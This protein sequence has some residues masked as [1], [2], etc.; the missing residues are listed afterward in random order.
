MD[1]NYVKAKSNPQ[2][3]DIRYPSFYDYKMDKKE[4][5]KVVQ[6]YR[7]QVQHRMTQEKLG[8]LTNTSRTYIAD[9]ERGHKMPSELKRLSICRVLNIPLPELFSDDELALITPYGPLL[10]EIIATVRELPEQKQNNIL[11]IARAY[12]RE[13]ASEVASRKGG[14]EVVTAWGDN[15]HEAGRTKSRRSGNSG[16]VAKITRKNARNTVRRRKSSG[17]EK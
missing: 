10:A 3:I 14:V 6:K 12:E 5:G 4:I 13:H 11:D 17:E 1:D 15:H 2:I 7:L 8:E 9:I 16:V